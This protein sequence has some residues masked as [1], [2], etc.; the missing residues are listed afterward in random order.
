[1]DV[2][3]KESYIKCLQTFSNVLAKLKEDFSNENAL[4]ESAK[5]P[6]EKG[7]HLAERTLIIG[8]LIMLDQMACFMYH[9]IGLE[10]ERDDIRNRFKP[11]K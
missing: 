4:Y 5:T 9:E 7:S 2:D 3:Y 6:Q 10:V 8:K 11:D 1:M